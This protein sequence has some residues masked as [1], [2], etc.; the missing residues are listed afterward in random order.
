MAQCRHYR[1]LMGAYVDGTAS[2][3]ER[4]ALRRHL[5]ECAECATMLRELR[6]VRRLVTGLPTL[7]PSAALRP[8]LAARLRAQRVTWFDRVFGVLRPGELRLAVTVALL[9]VIAIGAG[10][11]TMHGPGPMIGPGV[12]TAE[13]TRPYVGSPAPPAATDEYLQACALAHGTLD[14]DQAY[15]GADSVQLASYVP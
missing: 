2:E 11:V 8:A 6:G 4:A 10:V 1:T 13:V 15:W 14:Q 9:L 7:R 12:P 3:A 5:D